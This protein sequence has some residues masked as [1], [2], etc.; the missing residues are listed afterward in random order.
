MVYALFRDVLEDWASL[1]FSL[2][3]ILGAGL[4]SG[5]TVSTVS[6]DPVDLRI[7]MRTGTKE[8]KHRAEALL[9]LVT[10]ASHHRLLVT[11]LLGNALVNE[12]LPIFLNDLFP[13]WAAVLLSVTMVLIV[14]EILPAAVFTGPQKLAIAASFAPSVWCIM[15]ILG[16]VA[17]PIAWVLDRAIPVKAEAISR[18]QVRAL[19]EI[20]RE[21]AKEGGIPEPFLED[22]EDMIKGALSLGS[23]TVDT[24]D[25]L[26]PIN[27][28][29]SL[30]F[31]ARLNLSTLKLVLEKGF[32][33]VPVVHHESSVLLGYLLVKD[34]I[35]LNPELAEPISDM[36]LYAPVCCRP[37]RLLSDLLNDFQTGASHMAFIARDP[38]L[39]SRALAQ[40]RSL[41]MD[42]SAKIPWDILYSI[43][44]SGIVGIVTLEDV[45]E[46][47]L[48][49]EV[50]DESDRKEALVT[51]GR[52]L[53]RTAL[54]KLKRNIL[55]HRRD[56]T[57]SAAEDLLGPLTSSNTTSYCFVPEPLS[58]ESVE[59]TSLL[60]KNA[61]RSD[62]EAG[63]ATFEPRIPSADDRVFHATPSVSNGR[64]VSSLL[65][66]ERKQRH[67]RL[68]SCNLT[69]PITENNYRQSD[70]STHEVHSSKV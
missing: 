12:A 60:N 8:D 51:L 55:S 61:P 69:L 38:A 63:R 2:I 16:P 64:V 15:F 28:V 11:L 32:S 50:Y 44:I 62:I 37:T 39:L 34:F 4:F 30:P 54:P 58:P 20:H 49:E 14:G 1:G 17:V 57:S 23:I 29:F 48:T 59:P 56:D 24:A 33:R 3:C 26:T 40:F 45:I 31:D 67:Q 66:G 5:L 41:K 42:S 9:P 18:N 19:V 47:L 13:T 6:I 25:V 21:L 53:K 36:E 43:K 22:E 35:V 65:M 10:Q 70:R 52:F 7:V 68:P 46:V 27:D